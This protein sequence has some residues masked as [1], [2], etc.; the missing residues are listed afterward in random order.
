MQHSFSV[1]HALRTSSWFFKYEGDIIKAIGRNDLLLSAE[2]RAPINVTNFFGYGNDTKLNTDDVNYFRTRYNVVNAS[3]LLRRQ[4]QSW[5][6][7]YAGPTFQ[8]F[9]LEEGE[10]QG[11]FVDNTINNGLDPTTLYLPKTYAGA[12]FKLDINSKNNQV[13]PT[14]GF[15][16]DA[17]VKQLFGLNGQSHTVTQLRW[18]MSVFASFVP[19][20]M[21]VIATRIG[22]YRNFGNFEFPQA[23]YLSGTDNLRGYRRNRFAGRTMFFNNTELRFKL[24]NF[25]TYL[26]PGSLGLLAFHDIGRVWMDNQSSEK[27]HRGYGAGIWISPIQRFVITASVAHSEEEKILPYVTFGFQF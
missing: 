1:G 5:M 16:L 8:H 14:R 13:L 24:T 7:V 23:N 3:V 11:K 22:Y 2:A 12:E 20:S 27:W 9:K 15:L 26:F 10:N 25:N 18:D 21:Y 6:R 4:L 17:G 19:Q